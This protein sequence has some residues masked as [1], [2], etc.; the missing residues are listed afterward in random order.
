MKVIIKKKLESI[1]KT[2]F[3]L[4]HFFI[5]FGKNTNIASINIRIM[6]VVRNIAPI[7][8]N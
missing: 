2:L 6:L 7:S 4:C 1:R 5:L 8:I 3:N